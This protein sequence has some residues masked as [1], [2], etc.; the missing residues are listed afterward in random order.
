[1]CS[2][3]KLDLV[4]SLGADQV[5]D[6]TGEDLASAGRHDVIIDT[7]GS[8]PFRELLGC[9]TASGTLVVVGSGIGMGHLGGLDRSLTGPIRNLLTRQ[10]LRG[11]LAKTKRA[12]LSTLID[13]TASGDLRP[14]I[15]A[16][17]S[18]DQAS[19]ALRVLGAG[20]SMGKA[21]IVP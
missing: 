12:D 16:R 21:V 10:H 5:L 20:H 9:L 1:V 17:Y 11:L 4:R 6:Y 8:R 18:L 7:A 13:L 3:D 14:A 2:T 15:T 19:E